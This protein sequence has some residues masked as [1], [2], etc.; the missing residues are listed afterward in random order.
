MIRQRLVLMCLGA[1]AP[2]GFT[3]ID[4]APGSRAPDTL[5]HRTILIGRSVDGRPIAAIE[6]GDGDSPMKT[7]VVGCIHGNEPGGIAVA[8][9]LEHTTPPPETD[10]WIIP[11]LNPD[12]VAN[13]TR[14]NADGVDLNRNFP[15]RWMPL[16][17]VYD[18]GPRP[19]SEP[20]SRLAARLIR[21][22]R[23]SV[24]IWFH[25][26]L[27]VVDDSTGS[28]QIERRFARVA[29]LPVAPLTPE[30]GSAVTW[31]SRRFPGATAFVVELP[32]GVLAPAALNRLALA[33][34]AASV[35]AGRHGRWATFSVGPLA[36]AFA[37]FPRRG[38]A[39]E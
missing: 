14:G 5:T 4:P 19:L 6:T 8:A 31:E 12:G 1:L 27:D 20:E 26:H 36:A 29:D 39:G 3:S 13:G 15:A 10:T 37:V 38:V 7:L 33:V 35:A 25:Q 34:R 16:E 21:R 18:S 17:G 28:R 24:S 2:C 30:P 23:P 32:A 11:D 9:K 22:I